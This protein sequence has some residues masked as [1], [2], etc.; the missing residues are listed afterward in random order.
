MYDAMGLF[1]KHGHAVVNIQGKY[2]AIDTDNCV[3]VPLEYDRAYYP[4]IDSAI[5]F[6]KIGQGCVCFSI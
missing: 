1:D 4:G 6:E 5:G 2:G 3:V